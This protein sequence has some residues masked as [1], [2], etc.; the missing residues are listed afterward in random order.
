MFLDKMYTLLLF[1]RAQTIFFEFQVGVFHRIELCSATW[2]KFFFIMFQLCSD[3]WHRLFL[4][5]FWIMPCDMVQI[6][7]IMFSTLFR[8]MFQII[9]MGIASYAPSTALETGNYQ[10]KFEKHVRVNRTLTNRHNLCGLLVITLPCPFL[11][12]EFYNKIRR[13]K[14]V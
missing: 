11:R 7:F 10:Y 6:G 14:G 12:I 13:R 9:Y 4:I 8:D 1:Y 5:M 3:T 2:F